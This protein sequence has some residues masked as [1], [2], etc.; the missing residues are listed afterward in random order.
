MDC[1][2]FFL[3]V[4]NF[5]KTND[6]FWLVLFLFLYLI[7]SC[8]K[9]WHIYIHVII[10]YVKNCAI[11]W[12][13]VWIQIVEGSGRGEDWGCKQT[14]LFL[15]YNWEMLVKLHHFFGD[16]RV[17]NSGQLKCYTHTI[18]F[19]QNIMSIFKTKW[20]VYFVY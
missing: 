11:I 6:K 20:T 1:A 15:L 9:I 5:Y 17:F 2:K 3:I 7:L 16:E 19:L 12:P 4:I 10:G 13:F 8:F 18:S 14:S